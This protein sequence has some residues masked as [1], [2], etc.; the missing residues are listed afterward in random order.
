MRMIITGASRGIGAGIAE[1]CVAKGHKVGLLARSADRLAKLT[2]N[3]GP[4]ACWRQA[5]VGDL[6]QVT[7]AINALVAQLGGLDAMVINAGLS[8]RQDLLQ[9][10]PSDWQRM[11]DTNVH[12]SWNSARAS[13]P[14]LKASEQPKRHLI[15]ISSISGR[16]P[17][18]PGSGY[19][20]TKYAVTGLAESLFLELREHH[21]ATSVV[22][23]GSVAT[24]L[25]QDQPGTDH[26][27]MVQPREVGEAICTIIDQPGNT[28][29]HQMEIRPLQR[30]H[31]T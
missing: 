19:A 31:R 25:H 2:H 14:H 23:P 10:Q 13:V 24:K 4:L 1:A 8:I 9:L 6:D 3:L 18:A 12:G 27:L 22:Y 7:T 30:P 28:V 11:V 29:I 17:L 16:L 26:D 20:A 5:D 15:F 21:I